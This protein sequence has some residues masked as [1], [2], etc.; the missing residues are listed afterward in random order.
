MCAD[1]TPSAPSIWI[2]IGMGLLYGIFLAGLIYL[3]DWKTERIQP[4]Y[5]Y[6]ALIIIFIIYEVIRNLFMR[7][8]A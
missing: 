3:V 4:F 1:F 6:L 2:S 7:Y 5:Y 8:R